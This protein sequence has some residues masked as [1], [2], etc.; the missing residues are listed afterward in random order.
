MEAE[1]GVLGRQLDVDE[2]GQD[3]QAPEDGPEHEGARPTHG[4]TAVGLDAVDDP[5]Q[6]GDETHAEGDVPGPVDPGPDPHTV[7]DEL[8]IR[9]D[10]AEDAERHADQKDEAPGDRGQEPSDEQPDEGPGDGGHAVDAEGQAALVGREGVGQD[11]A[12]V[13]EQECPADPL[14]DPHDDEPEGAR[15]PASSR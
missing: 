13:G 4:V 8:H 7:V 12:G 10:G 15:R 5:G 2:Q 11:G 9:P 6:D 1:H 14:E 3:R